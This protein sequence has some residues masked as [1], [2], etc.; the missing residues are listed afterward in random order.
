MHAARDTCRRPPPPRARSARW[1]RRRPAARRRWS[2]RPL[3]GSMRSG[4]KA[5][6]TSRPGRSPRSASGCDEQLAWCCPRSVVLVSTITWSRRACC[7][8]RLAG[9]AQE[10]QVR[11]EAVV[12]RRRDADHD[13]VGG[14]ERAGA[15]REHEL[16][17]A[18][19]P[20]AGAPSPR[21]R[22][23]RCPRGCPA[24][25]ARS[26]RPRSPSLPAAAS[27]MPVGSPT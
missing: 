27:P 24:A 2:Q 12:D 19:A 17:R 14:L 26:R 18:R 6:N 16:V 15:R 25:A 22:G 9:G 5:T 8:D 4:E 1:R 21:P 20:T 23:P 13:R 11:L 10:P 7:D 3:P